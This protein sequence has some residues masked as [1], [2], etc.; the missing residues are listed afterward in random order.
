MAPRVEIRTFASSR[1]VRRF[2]LFIARVAR[3][4]FKVFRRSQVVF[5]TYASGLQIVSNPAA[6]LQPSGLGLSRLS[7][8][9]YRSIFDGKFSTFVSEVYW[10]ARGQ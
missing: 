3:V 1:D 7:E 5:T 4:R 6:L 8:I 10:C 2:S 9:N